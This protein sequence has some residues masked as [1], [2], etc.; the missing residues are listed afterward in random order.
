MCW[1]WILIYQSVWLMTT[2]TQWIGW[3]QSPRFINASKSLIKQALICPMNLIHH[4]TTNNPHRLDQSQLMYLSMHG[5]RCF[6]KGKG[7]R[8]SCNIF[9]F[10]ITWFCKSQVMTF[11]GCRTKCITLVTTEQRRLT[12][13]ILSL[14]LKSVSWC[15]NAL[16]NWS[17]PCSNQDYWG[18]IPADILLVDTIIIVTWTSTLWI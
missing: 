11:S 8:M 10:P 18:C 2:M 17:L 12:K 13:V 7:K 4:F 16:L 9:L 3:E 14:P 1:S 5:F 15:W 6:L